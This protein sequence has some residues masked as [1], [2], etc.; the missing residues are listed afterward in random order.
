M[1]PRVGT[2][3]FA[4]P[5]AQ[6]FRSF[7][8]IEIQQTFYQPPQPQT[9]QRW[10]QAAPENFVFTLKA[11]Q[12]ITHYPGSP[13][14]RRSRL[15]AAERH[16]CGEFRDTP[17]VRHAWHTT[18][19]IARLLKAPLVIFQCPAQFTPTAEH[20]KNLRSFFRWA[21][22][23]GLSFGFEPRGEAWHDELV[24][25]VCRECDLLH[26]VDPFERQSVWGAVRYYRLHGNGNVNPPAG[27]RH[28]Y[29]DQELRQ[30]VAWCDTAD[31][32][33][34]FNNV[35]MAEDALRFAKLVREK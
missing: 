4:L 23:D 17:V 14:Y 30:L 25:E 24:R 21:D 2:C 34:L 8:L 35:S 19:E 12:A 27:Y 11:F 6:Y 33:C 7:S 13:T 3:G 22:R 29:S 20:L 16:Q 26:V 15:S 28:R 10:R 1:P 32:Y 5:Q 18:L 31:C 9:A